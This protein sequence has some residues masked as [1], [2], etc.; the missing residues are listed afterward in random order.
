MIDPKDD[1]AQPGYRLVETSNWFRRMRVVLFG[2]DTKQRNTLRELSTRIEITNGFHHGLAMQGTYI[3]RR[4]V[5]IDRNGF[6]VRDKQDI[7]DGAARHA[8]GDLRKA[9]LPLIFSE[10]ADQYES[11]REERTEAIKN[12]VVKDFFPSHVQPE[13]K[14]SLP[15]RIERPRMQNVFDD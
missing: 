9:R 10:G 8:I 7:V 3:D 13:L 6:I 12:A 1:S 4:G 5:L 2:S 14:S 11:F 15:I